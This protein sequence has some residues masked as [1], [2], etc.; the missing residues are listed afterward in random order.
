MKEI[1]I[2]DG[3]LYTRETGKAIVAQDGALYAYDYENDPNPEN[4]RTISGAHVHINNE[5]YIDGGAGGK[6][7]GNGAVPRSMFPDTDS[8]ERRKLKKEAELKAKQQAEQHK[9][10]VEAAREQRKQERAEATKLKKE[11]EAQMKLERAELKPKF[12]EMVKAYHAEKDPKK[13]K[14]ILKE[15][16]AFVKD[17]KSKYGISPADDNI[18]VQKRSAELNPTKERPQD[19]DKNH[20]YWKTP[21][22]K[23]E[24]YFSQRMAAAEHGTF[25]RQDK[26]NSIAEAARKKALSLNSEAAGI[27]QEIDRINRKRNYTKEDEENVK[28]LNKKRI[29]A[30]R[31]ANAFTNAWRKWKEENNVPEPEHF[32]RVVINI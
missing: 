1:I 28:E 8:A 19:S 24:Q 18:R 2:V 10:E 22:G 9:K 32:K 15:L 5:G 12:D 21:E 31:E 29:E 30:E 13:K 25:T 3:K 27:N 11:K 26:I 7:N 20:P 17:Y 6:F 16:D 14:A 4:W 23:A